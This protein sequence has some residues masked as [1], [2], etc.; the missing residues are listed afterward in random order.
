[1]TVRGRARRRFLAAD[2][3]LN[4]AVFQAHLDQPNLQF[5]TNKSVRLWPAVGC[6][7]ISRIHCGAFVACGRPLDIIVIVFVV[8]SCCRP[9]LRCMLHV[10]ASS[11]AFAAGLLARR[12]HECTWAD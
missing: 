4:T 12:F 9:C 1:M 8:L 2:K 7:Q 11:S 5:R 3:L 10:S 6:S